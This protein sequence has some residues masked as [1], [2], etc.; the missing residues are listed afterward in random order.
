M[1]AA[2]KTEKSIE[3][4]T[5]ATDE[6]KN[7]QKSLAD[8]I[9][10]LT[11]TVMEVAI[12]K[13]DEEKQ[14][15]IDLG[16]SIEEVNEWYDLEIEKLEEAN[17][18]KDDAIDVNTKLAKS[19][20]K[21][22]DSIKGIG[23]ETNKTSETFEK[24]AKTA[25]K[26]FLSVIPFA[27]KQASQ[28]MNQFTLESL[29]A[30][31][32][33]IKMRYAPTI[34]RAE[35][36]VRTTTV[37]P[38][39]TMYEARLQAVLEQM[40]QEISI[41]TGGFKEYFQILAGL[42]GGSAGAWPAGFSFQAGTPYVPQTGLAMVHKGEAIIPA[43]QNTYDQ[44]KNYSSINIQPGSIVIN[45]PKFSENDAAEMLRLIKRRAA[46]QGQKFATI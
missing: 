31:I 40:R 9:F 45:T 13:L 6:F 26:T 44:R 5:E 15:Y 11:H 30:A 46:M 34:F 37:V 35:E 25:T 14:S 42:T 18:L 39:R 20:K 38:I 22:G 17:E 24:I 1:L 29:A 16:M 43:S 21:V 12:K 7:A 33:N 32:A 4:L 2:K 8:K 28:A 36:A 19:N 27:I 3:S 10:E 23:R 41:I